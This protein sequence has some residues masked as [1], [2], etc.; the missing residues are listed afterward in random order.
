MSNVNKDTI[1]NF[2][3]YKDMP[4][5]SP[6]FEIYS[7][8]DFPISQLI[9]EQSPDFVGSQ[10]RDQEFLAGRMKRN[11]MR[12]RRFLTIRWTFAFKDDRTRSRFKEMRR[13]IR[14]RDAEY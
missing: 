5:S 14:E 1:V 6:G 13:C 10:I 2:T 7:T 3:V 8:F 12:M 11:F 4:R 9:L